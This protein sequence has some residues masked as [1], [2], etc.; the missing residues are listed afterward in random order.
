LP[1]NSGRPAGFGFFIAVLG[2]ILSVMVGLAVEGCEPFHAF[3]RW[4]SIMTLGAVPLVYTCGQ[5]AAIST[6]VCSA[7]MLVLF[8][9]VC[10]PHGANGIDIQIPG[11]PC[12]LLFAPPQQRYDFASPSATEFL[13]QQK[14]VLFMVT[15]GDPSE[16]E[17]KWCSDGGA[18]QHVH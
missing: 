15:Q 14:A 9:V 3:S 16:F 5:N 4:F 2:V 1:L 12:S 17:T 11:Q 6:V 10:F 8:I 13:D 18:N 7:V